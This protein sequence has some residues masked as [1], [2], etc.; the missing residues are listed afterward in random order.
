M[1][2]P[3]TIAALAMTAV[4]TAMQYQGQRKAQKAMEAAAAAESG[5]QRK[6][7]DEAQ[8]LFQE[9][10]GQQEAGTQIKRIADAKAEREAATA[11]NMQ[12]APVVNVP[13]QG[14]TPSIVADETAARVGEGNIRA[15]DEAIAKAALASFGDVQLGN[16]LLNARYGAQQGQLS[17]FMQGSYGVLPTELSAASKAG[18]K[19]KLFG[20]ML[21][22]GGQIAGMYGMGAGSASAANSSNGIVGRTGLSSL[23]SKGIPGTAS[24]GSPSW[25]MGSPQMAY[26]GIKNSSMFSNPTIVSGNLPYRIPTK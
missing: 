1:C 26:G 24:V 6:L 25:L 22:A 3:M 9:S 5:R 19:L 21:V 7:R 17:N 4:G 16:A 11:G 12:S 15:R 10:L 20:D 2:E 18:D 13:T 8:G 23:Q 14:A